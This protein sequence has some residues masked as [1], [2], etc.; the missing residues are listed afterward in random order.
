MKKYTILC[1]FTAFFLCQYTK[2]KEINWEQNFAKIEY[3]YQIGD[4]KNGLEKLKIFQ[5]Q[6]KSKFGEQSLPMSRTIALQAKFYVALGKFS[7]YKKTINNSVQLFSSSDKSDANQSAK[8]LNEITESYISYYEFLTAEGYNA[9][10]RKLV[11]ENKVTDRYTVNRINLAY[12]KIRTN[13]GYLNQVADEFTPL[14]NSANESLTVKETIKDS[15]G[16]EKAVK[17][18]KEEIMLRQKIYASMANTKAWVMIE[19]GEYQQADLLLEQTEDWIQKTIGMKEGAYAEALYLQAMIALDNS[20]YYEVEKK[21]RKAEVVA[22]GFLKPDAELLMTI[23][24]SL[25]PTLKELEKNKEAQIKNEEVDAKIKGYYGRKNFAY[26]RNNLIDTRRDILN[27]DWNKAQRDLENFLSD[28][29]VVPADHLWRANALLTLYEVYMKN[30]KIEKAEKSLFEAINIKK[31][32]LGDKAPMYHMTQLK[33][34]GH[35]TAAGDQFKVSE[36]IYS[37]SLDKIIKK[38]IGHKNRYYAGFNYDEIKL[39]LLTDRFE[40]AYSIAKEML[41]ETEKF[42]SPNSVQYAVSLEKYA[43]V[44][45]VTGKYT[46]ADSKL[47]KS[48]NLFQEKGT[49]R[50]RLNQAHALESK[51]RLQILLGLFEEA[52]ATLR[53]SNK[54]TKRA[55]NGEVKFSSTSEEIT[56]LNIYLGKYSETEDFL[57]ELLTSR[58][59][60]YGP[61]SSSLVNPWDLLG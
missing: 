27:Q 18:S 51:A 14:M 59:A 54:L 49:Y 11:A 45:I 44:D 52:D 25:I 12:L 42:Y 53:K 4:Y 10:A 8:A 30:N 46:E 38:E 9:Q 15:K 5:E 50:D 35:Y 60:K 37:N 28:T 20:D 34:A 13:L 21:L 7:E 31:Q 22:I 29:A 24:E 2:A 32:K 3:A 47:N 55:E 6:V 41:A 36:A 1:F 61:L 58:E 26:Q 17:Y 23:E 57:N 48:I 33:L 56:E 19:N 39:Y 43:T 16:K 40:K